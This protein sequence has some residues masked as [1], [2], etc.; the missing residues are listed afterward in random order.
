MSVREH[1]EA[2]DEYL[3]AVEYLD[4]RSEGLGDRF[5]DHVELALADIVEDPTGWMKVPW[6]DEPPTLRWRS[7]G[8]FRTHVVY[9]LVGDEVHVIAY[10]HEAREPGYWRHRLD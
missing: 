9:R 7:V 5:V 4:S 3:D 2:R 6:W 1:P 8:P 10:A